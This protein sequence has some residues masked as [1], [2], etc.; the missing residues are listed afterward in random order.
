M[1]LWKDVTNTMESKIKPKLTGSDMERI[2]HQAFGS[3]VVETKE[4][5]D[6]WANSAYA[7]ITS[8]DRDVILKAAPFKGTKMMRYEANLMRTEVE[9]LRLF[10]NSG[11]LPVPKVL[12]HDDSCTLIHAEY[13]IMERLAG[14]PYN[15]MKET[16]S[17]E[18]KDAIEFELGVYSRLINEVQGE[19]FG[20][21]LQQ[22]SWKDSW[23]EAFQQMIRGV[24][25]DGRDA[26][27]ELP[28][29]DTVIESEIER[30][31]DA[32]HEVVQPRLVHWDL[33]DGNVFV[34]HGKITG[35]IDFERALWGDPLMEVYFGRFNRSVGFSRGYGLAVA[36]RNQRR[37]R[38]LYDFYL[39]LILWIECTYRQY[40]NNDH[41]NWALNNLAEGW[42]RLLSIGRD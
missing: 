26:G 29:V 23:A 37:R 8:D 2:I 1:N 28:A 18:E 14:A 19:K 3:R 24:L 12:A 32:L 9:A 40:E 15:K 6:G 30:H 17:Q 41:C 31:L 33:W 34:E 7:I 21:F 13:F 27:V 38:V 42:E 39:D 4:L 10:D 5:T 11:T 22:E 25:A 35:L 20:Y 16:L 36:T